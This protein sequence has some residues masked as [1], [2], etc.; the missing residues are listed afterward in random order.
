[1]VKKYRGHIEEVQGTIRKSGHDEEVQ[2]TI[3]KTVRKF[4][5]R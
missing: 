2:G 4:R 5:A 1:M 3:R